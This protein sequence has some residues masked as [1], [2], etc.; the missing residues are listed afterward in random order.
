MTP[1]IVSRQVR[2]EL[3]VDLSLMTKTRRDASISFS[4]NSPGARRWL[5][6]LE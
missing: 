4:L 5:S 3:V 2:F 1:I 6:L